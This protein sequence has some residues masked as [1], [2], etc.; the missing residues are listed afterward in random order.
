MKTACIEDIKDWLRENLT[1]EK[2]VHSLGTADAAREIAKICGGDEEKAYFT[3]LIHDCAKNLPLDEMISLIKEGGIKLEC[4]EDNNAKILH[5]PAGAALA[6]KVFGVEDDEILSAIR[7]HTL[8]QV[9]MTLLEKIIFLADKIEP[10]TRG[11]ECYLKRLETLSAP[12]GLEK[13]IL[14][15]YSYTIKSL[16]DRKLV[17]CQKTIEIYNNLLKFCTK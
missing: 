1:A 13:N 12:C 8:G 4:G 5:A 9:E 15:C 7:W 17:I 16:V 3:G 11:R 2:Y 6:K 14:D 10:E